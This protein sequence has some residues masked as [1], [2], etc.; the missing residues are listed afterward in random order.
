M[1][2]Q[3]LE[4]FKALAKTPEFLTMIVNDALMPCFDNL[5]TVEEMT[6]F[7]I[8][9]RDAVKA[10]WWVENM[11]MAIDKWVPAERETLWLEALNLA[12]D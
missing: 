5:E 7:F 4:T 3:Y 2:S 11:E 9:Y 10:D 6:E 8:T 1:P 12:V